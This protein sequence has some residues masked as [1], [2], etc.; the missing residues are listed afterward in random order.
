MLGKPSVEWSHGERA[1]MRRVLSKYNQM[2]VSC[3]VVQWITPTYGSEI[4]IVISLINVCSASICF[5]QS[6]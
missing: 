3:H 6:S 2:L 4:R 5:I 1:Y